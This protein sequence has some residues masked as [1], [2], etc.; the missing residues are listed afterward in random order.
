M[1]P[2]GHKMNLET[3]KRAFANDD[4]AIVEC[5][6]KVTGKPVHALCAIARDDDSFFIAPLAKLFDGN[7]Y[8]ELNP[9][10]LPDD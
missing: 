5:T 1:I 7:P 8:E 9:P 6:D 3:L 2:K 4:M 10:E